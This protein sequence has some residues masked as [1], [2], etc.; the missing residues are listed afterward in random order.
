MGTDFRGRTAEGIIQEM[1]ECRQHHDITV[2]D[3][4]DDNFTFDKRRAKKFLS[5]IIATFGQGDLQLSAM[6]GVS[7]A[8]LDRALL[9]LMKQAGFKEV[10]LSLVSV[11]PLIKAKMQRP[12]GREGFD[13]I[14]SEAVRV[15]LHVIAYA[16]LGMPGQTV[17]EMVDTLIYLMGKE[18]L[19]GPS[20][21]Y[22]IPG[23]PLFRRCQQEGLLPPNISQLRSSAL[24]IETAEFNRLDIATLLRLARLINF[25][26]GRMDRG[27]LEEGMTW[28]ELHQELKAR[29]NE[30]PPDW[31]ELLL[32][33]IN[34]RYFFSRRTDLAGRP[35]I[36]KLATSGRV[37]DNFFK[38]AWDAPIL[39]DYEA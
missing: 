13:E 31:R 18:V 16:I 9:R 8:S 37:L 25:L 22:P 39:K 11:D 27:E 38:D 24:P 6:N 17:A 19:I 5:L 7:F 10:N 20:V 4:E 32:L 33:L 35:S 30:K 21:Y 34:D 1:A 2:F 3:I 36:A 15:G 23:T 28:R 29:V 14:A 12:G 26:K